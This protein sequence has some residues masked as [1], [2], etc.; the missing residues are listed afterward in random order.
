MAAFTAPPYRMPSRSALPQ[1]YKIRVALPQ[2]RIVTLSTF[3][4]VCG[5]LNETMKPTEYYYRV[6]G[7]DMADHCRL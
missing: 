4:R 5:V 1:Q 6:G 7:A 2:G 3:A